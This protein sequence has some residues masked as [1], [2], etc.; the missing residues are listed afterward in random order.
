MANKAE[1][2]RDGKKYRLILHSQ[3]EHRGGVHIKLW[4]D[5]G[6]CQ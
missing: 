3:Q 5:Q 1:I 2:R 6:V 4:K